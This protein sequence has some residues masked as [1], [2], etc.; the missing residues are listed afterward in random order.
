MVRYAEE[1]CLQI[2]ESFSKIS[3][4]DHLKPHLQEFSYV[5]YPKGHRLYFVS[6]RSGRNC[7][8]SF[9]CHIW[10]VSLSAQSLAGLARLS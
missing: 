4:P 5:F 6:S 9:C 3:I 1:N 7:L 2:K 8:Q 10:S